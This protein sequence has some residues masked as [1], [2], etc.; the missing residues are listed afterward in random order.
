VNPAQ[1]LLVFAVR[2]YQIVISP[3]KTAVFGPLARCRFEPTCS[4]Y[5]RESV[6]VHGALRGS[7][8]A[9]RRLC[10]CHPWGGEGHD[11][12]PP[13]ALDSHADRGSGHPTDCLME[14]R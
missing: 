6:Q 13:A 9:V 2:A 12:V 14:S 8:L 1:H 7:W 4:Q 10:R 3:V 5:A 11:P